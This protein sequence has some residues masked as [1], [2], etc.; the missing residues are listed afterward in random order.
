[1]VMMPFWQ[2]LRS[3]PLTF[4][5]SHLHTHTACSF[6]SRSIPVTMDAGR[7]LNPPIIRLCESESESLPQPSECCLGPWPELEVS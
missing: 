3:H 1:M 5:G 6:A 7:N 4:W 2:S